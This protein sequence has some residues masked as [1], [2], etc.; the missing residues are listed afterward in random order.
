M[1]E[2]IK[3]DFRVSNSS[4]KDVSLKSTDIDEKLKEANSRVFST[5]EKQS[6]SLLVQLEKE[7]TWGTLLD[8][9]NE[10]FLTEHEQGTMADNPFLN[11][12]FTR[13]VNTTD[14]EIA[15]KK[16]ELKEENILNHEDRKKGK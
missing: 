7:L 4:N 12:N 14:I 6:Y 8:I 15:K 5:S 16:I 1:F 10:V 2:P 11:A 3:P 9:K 13:T